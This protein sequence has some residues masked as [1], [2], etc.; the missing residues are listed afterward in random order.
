DLLRDLAL[1]N[2]THDVFAVIIDSAFAFELP[3]M[4]AGW[5]EIADVESGETRVLSR[6]AYRR[7]AAR[8]TEWQ[9]GVAR[10]AKALDLDIVRIGPDTAQADLALSEFVAERRLRKTAS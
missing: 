8:I 1:L 7:M 3:T 10:T 9:A 5:I 4:S 2:A 6:A